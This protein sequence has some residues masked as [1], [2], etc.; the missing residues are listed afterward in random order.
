M[1]TILDE[2]GDSRSALIK[3]L[4]LIE[5]RATEERLISKHLSPDLDLTSDESDVV[6]VN[7]IWRGDLPTHHQGMEVVVETGLIPPTTDTSDD[8]IQETTKALP[9]VQAE[10]MVEVETPPEQTETV[11]DGVE[12][13]RLGDEG[14]GPSVTSGS[15]AS[16]DDDVEDVKR[17]PDPGEWLVP[18]PPTDRWGLSR[19]ETG[20]EGGTPK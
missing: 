6:R 15:S 5:T 18:V 3:A 12:P 8:P 19:R 4:R 2:L 16:R 13:E 1:D 9:E 17:G 11:V 20:V 10:M 14:W 7:L